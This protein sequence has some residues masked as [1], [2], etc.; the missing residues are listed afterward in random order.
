MKIRTIRG[1]V[2]ELRQVDPD[3]SVTEYT[4]RQLIKSGVLPV[5]MSGNRYLIN[6]D[7]LADVLKGTDTRI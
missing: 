1:A 3:T 7:T 4:L 2:A 5:V 6:M